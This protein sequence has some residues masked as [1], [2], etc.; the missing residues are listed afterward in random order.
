MH[1]RTAG[2]ILASTLT[3]GAAGAVAITPV[4]AADSDHPVTS[5]LTGIKSALSG[6][7]DD[8]TLTQEQADKVASTLAD[9]LPPGGMGHHDGR[10]GGRGMDAAAK[11]LGLTEAQLRARLSNGKSLADVARSEGV[12]KSTLIDAMVA[13]AEDDLA[14]AVKNGKITQAQADTM[15]ES[16]TDRI[17]DHV[18]RVRPEHGRGRGDAGKP[19]I[20]DPPADAP[21][22]S[23]SSS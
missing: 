14:A 20:G 22:T 4:N 11:A 9:K 8:G 15:K 23:S 10:F 12:S 18:N 16:L 13:A 2:L 19:F 7:V 5:R 1:K 3:I 6:L 17:T 21:D